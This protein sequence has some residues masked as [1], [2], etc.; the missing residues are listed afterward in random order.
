MTSL[1]S[2][3]IQGEIPCYKIYE[4]EN[5]FAFL[6]NHPLQFGHTLVIPKRE[7]GNVLDMDDAL[8]SHLMLVAKNII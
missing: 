4:D 2:R 8:Y 7:V 5:I 6:D 3:I 1:F